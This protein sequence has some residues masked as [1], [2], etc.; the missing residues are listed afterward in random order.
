M[1]MRAIFL[2]VVCGFALAGCK[3]PIS[4]SPP[5]G[6]AVSPA[7]AKA[8]G[9]VSPA[10]AKAPGASG[11]V[12]PSS[13]SPEKPGASEAPALARAAVEGFVRTP[14]GLQYEVLVE[15]RGESPPL[16]S[17]VLLHYTG[18]LPNGETFASTRER[19]APQEFKLDGMSLIGG[20]VEALVSMKKGEQRKLLVPSALAYGQKGYPGLVLPNSDLTFELELVAFTPPGAGKAPR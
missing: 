10:P 13:A 7:P 14:S 16:G 18:R 20:W 1:T 12:T 19:G 4:S 5:P 17:R 2:S 6:G 3:D 8:P 15:G 9:A 11:A